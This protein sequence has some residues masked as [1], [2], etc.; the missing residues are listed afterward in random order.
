MQVASKI[1]KEIVYDK[2]TECVVTYTHLVN[3]AKNKQTIS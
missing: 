1:Q 2:Y 3:T